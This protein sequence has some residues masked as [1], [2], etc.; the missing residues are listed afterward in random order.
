MKFLVPGFNEVFFAK[1]QCFDLIIICQINIYCLTGSALSKK[2]QPI[3]L[4][5]SHSFNQ[6]N[7]YE[8]NERRNANHMLQ[9]LPLNI[10]NNEIAKTNNIWLLFFLGPL[11]WWNNVFTHQCKVYDILQQQKLLPRFVMRHDYMVL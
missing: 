11:T 3:S 8:F 1:I 4:V 2:I 10:G 7:K 5:I 9:Y 6:I